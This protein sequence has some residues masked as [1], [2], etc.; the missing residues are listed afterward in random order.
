MPIDEDTYYSTVAAADAYFA[1]R[2]HE[3]DWSASSSENREKAL[4]A[5]TQDI[6]A[7]VFAGL[8][9]PAYDLLVAD[10]DATDAEL[11]AAADTQLLEFPR[12]GESDVPEAI[13]IATYEIAHERLRGRDPAMELENL[14]LTSDGIGSTRLTS[15]RSQMPPPH[16]SNGIVSWIAW[17]YLKPY[18]EVANYFAVKRI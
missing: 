12:D 2:L 5:A 6:D 4:L 18:L 1:N 11:Q 13:L 15:D 10:P 8:K 3:Y 7:L 17:R 9:T 14:V 16:L